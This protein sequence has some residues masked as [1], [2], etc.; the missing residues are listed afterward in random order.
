[1]PKIANLIRSFIPSFFFFISFP[2]VLLLIWNGS[3]FTEVLVGGLFPRSDAYS[4]L[5]DAIT[6]LFKG[7]FLPYNRAL[8]PLF[9]ASLLYLTGFRIWMV[10]LTITI[11][12]GIYATI[13]F[14]QLRKLLGI[15]PGLFFWILLLTLG[16]YQT[17]GVLMSESLGIIFGLIAL[18]TFYAA[19]ERESYSLYLLGLIAFSVGLCV[20]PGTL[21]VLPLLA[22]FTSTI[23]QHKNRK[24]LR[25]LGSIICI[26][27]VF[28]FHSRFVAYVSQGQAL[29]FDNFSYTLYG[30]ASGGKGFL[31][32]LQDYPNSTTAELYKHSIELIYKDP[33]LFLKGLS[34]SLYFFMIDG[35]FA[36]FL[37]N[38]ACHF[39]FMVGFY[40]GIYCLYK[41]RSNN[42]NK[43]LL[44]IVLGTF[45]SSP[46]LPDGGS[47]IYAVT[48]PFLILVAIYPICKLSNRRLFIS[49]Q[50]HSPL[51]LRS[52]LMLSIYLFPVGLFFLSC[53]ISPISIAKGLDNK[54]HSKQVECGIGQVALKQVL[55]FPGIS[56]TIINKSETKLNPPFTITQ[57]MWD[58]SA[59]L[60]NRF[61]LWFN[62][63]P[64][65]KDYPY[66]SF[67]YEISTNKL[68]IGFSK[69]RIAK[70]VPEFVNLCL[71]SLDKK[72]QTFIAII[73]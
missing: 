57:E 59:D 29:A 55:V 1:M 5:S 10:Q 8:F 44:L 20:R 63:Y 24:I 27:C 4:H 49:F 67:L 56:Q 32:F 47:R 35:S 54:W 13:T 51:E 21:L 15:L 69:N 61:S 28:Y 48:N 12:L 66:I 3:I 58:N 64:S 9:L 40:C 36:M 18:T 71:K 52:I 50:E 39:L 46:F 68:M 43:L 16:R 53:L 73:E 6:F 60:V 17:I 45:F 34:Y 11:L 26:L 22:I 31:H 19:I 7:H 37:R 30:I 25:I 72:S 14:I 2:L 41:E 62:P 23:L 65:V 70:K 42:F 33:F 38:K